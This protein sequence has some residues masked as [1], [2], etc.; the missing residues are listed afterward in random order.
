M[1]T[2]TCSQTCSGSEG[3]SRRSSV[4]LTISIKKMRLQ[5]DKNCINNLRKLMMFHPSQVPEPL[6]KLLQLG[7]IIHKKKKKS[8]TTRCQWNHELLKLRQKLHQKPHQSSNQTFHINHNW[9]H[10]NQMLCQ[11]SL[12]GPHRLEQQRRRKKD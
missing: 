8:H 11:L 5:R 1:Y 6:K 12:T 7:Q 4:W 10:K 3:A 9:N 2:Q